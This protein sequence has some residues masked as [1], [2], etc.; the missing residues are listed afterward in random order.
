MAFALLETPVA[1]QDRHIDIGAQHVVVAFAGH[2]AD[3]DL[4]V[5]FMKAVQ[6]RHQP[7]SSEGKVGGNLQD[8][9]LLLCADRA[10][11]CID[12]LQTESNLLKQYRADFGQL[13]PTVNA[14]K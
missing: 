14:I 2:Q 1:K 6:A 13:D 11:S 12:I 9:M 7:I 10:Q 4:R 3:V 5:G 8:F